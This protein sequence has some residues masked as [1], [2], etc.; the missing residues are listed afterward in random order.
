[1]AEW[2]EL[3]ASLLEPPEFRAEPLSQCDNCGEQLYCNLAYW[4][5]PDTDIMCCSKDCA[6]EYV[7]ELL[8]EETI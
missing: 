6:A 5:L 3:P 7:K 2:H 8:R 1:M 4:T